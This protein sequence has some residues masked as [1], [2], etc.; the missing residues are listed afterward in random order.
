IRVA[1]GARTGE[2]VR[3]F[4]KQSM[5]LAA[6]GIGLGT[7]LGF[8][9][10]RIL[11]AHIVFIN[12]FDL[13]AYGAGIMLVLA[14]TAAA[15]YFP[16]RRLGPIDLLSGRL[17]RIWPLGGGSPKRAQKGSGGHRCRHVPRRPAAARV[18]RFCAVAR[19]NQGSIRP[20]RGCP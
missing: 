18:R 15:T 11:A 14:A 5:R 3:L 7:S 17:D 1:L 20:R 19:Q 16:T 10:S 4:V 8:A 6:I 2:V 12:T 13:L 9:V